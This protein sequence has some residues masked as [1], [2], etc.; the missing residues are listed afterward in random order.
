MIIYKNPISILTRSDVPNENFTNEAD[1]FI[2]DD[3]SELGRKILQHAPF[4]EFVLE[5]GELV[6]IT[7]TER[8][9]EPEPQPTEVELLR[10]QV[11]AQ[12][13][14]IDDL[15]FNIIPTMTG[16]GL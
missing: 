16:D 8:P 5:N 12:Q 7:P 10:E 15:L 14:I 11:N 13:T 2:V 3:N 4:F 1:V 9:N 6:D